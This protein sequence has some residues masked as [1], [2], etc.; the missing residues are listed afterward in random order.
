[1]FNVLGHEAAVKAF[2]SATQGGRLH[3]AYFL[4]G[5]PHVGKLTLAT[6]I[7]Q[8]MNCL[9]PDDAPCGECEAC[10]RI[11]NGSHTDVHVLA[12]DPEATE[13]PKDSIGIKA[14]RELIAAA[15]LRPYEGRTRV[16][17]F[18]QAEQ[19]TNDAANALLKVLEEPPPD[20]LLL[21]LSA[22]ADR[23]LPTIKSRCQLI[24]L[25]PLPIERVTEI[26]H[27][28][29]VAGDQADSIARLSRGCIGWAM[30]ASHDPALLA[31]VHQGIE[32]I[33]GVIEDTLE[34]RFS[35]AEALARRFQRDRSEGREELYLWL[36]W[37]RD[38]LLVQQGREASIVN[39]SWSDTLRRQANAFTPADAVCW[40]HLITESIEFLERNANARLAL[41]VLMLE[42][43]RLRTA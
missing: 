10:T 26:L 24:K 21:L 8:A 20:V 42:A 27:E 40:L 22:D 18:D 32:R 17:I 19:M 4:A 34:S 6:Q 13:G 36:R 33:S 3:H 16:F 43:P 39:I 2:E 28:Q 41:D 12:I 25:H 1:M 30:D 35:Y 31:G 5:P 14:V 37:F 29:G 15:H 7:A 11:A 23:V 9:S 38:I